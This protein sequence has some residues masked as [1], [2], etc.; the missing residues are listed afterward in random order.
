M[1]SIDHSTIYRR[2]TVTDLMPVQNSAAVVVLRGRIWLTVDGLPDDYFL[3]AGQRFELA[4]AMRV[5][6]SGEPAASVGIEPMAAMPVEKTSGDFRLA[7]LFHNKLA[8]ELQAFAQRIVRS[9]LPFFTLSRAGT[10]LRSASE[11]VSEQGS[12]LGRYLSY[13]RRA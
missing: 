13:G 6:I 4:P 12:A 1:K 8:L 9:S 2:L 7:T 3:A 5:M 10:K 11:R